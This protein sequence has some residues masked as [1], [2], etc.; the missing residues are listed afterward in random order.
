[1]NLE[2]IG[3]VLLSVL[4]I[5]SVGLVVNAAPHAADWKVFK[6]ADDM[7][8]IET[9]GAH[10]GQQ[11][12][13]GFHLFG[14]ECGRP[15]TGESV[16]FTWAVAGESFYSS[17]IKMIVKVDDNPPQNLLAG[18]YNNSHDSGY[19]SF[20]GYGAGRELM[21]QLRAGERAR[22]RLQSST[23]T[24]NFSVSLK[25]FTKAGT[26]VLASCGK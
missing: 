5:C 9:I 25:G 23:T 20:I 24:V 12:A 18:P 17:S 15:Q 4:L 8:G 2:K 22:V 1:M 14:I 26:E 19:A 21:P 7:T 10:A 6:T 13:A 3:T 16:Y 11:V